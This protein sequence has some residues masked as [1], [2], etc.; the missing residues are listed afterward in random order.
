[1]NSAVERLTNQAPITPPFEAKVITDG[2]IGLNQLVHLDR[3]GKTNRDVIS[4]A[5]VNEML[6]KAIGQHMPDELKETIMGMDGTTQIILIQHPQSVSLLALGFP[7]KDS[8]RADVH[9]ALFIIEVERQSIFGNETHF[10]PSAVRIGGVDTKTNLPIAV[11]YVP[12]RLIDAQ[13]EDLVMRAAQIDVGTDNTNLG[14]QKENMT[15][16]LPTNTGGHWRDARPAGFISNA[17]IPKNPDYL[18]GLVYR[19]AIRFSNL[20]NAE[21]SRSTI[22]P[23]GRMLFLPDVINNTT[24]ARFEPRRKTNGFEISVPHQ[25][26]PRA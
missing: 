18:H 19:R 16:I 13:P 3:D 24:T 1:M 8:G 21:R 15:Y 17:M 25:L 23:A 20:Q 10:Y 26:T 11:A 5:Q 14:N 6:D 4:L 9:D 12:R 22:T 2:P 7:S